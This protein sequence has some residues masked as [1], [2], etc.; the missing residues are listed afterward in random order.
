[1]ES[2]R[3]VGICGGIGAG[4]SVVSR[5]LRLRGYT[6]YDCDFEARR[7]MDTSALFKD[8]LEERFGAEILSDSPSRIIDRSRLAALV[9]S[10]DKALEWLNTRVHAMVRD[11][12]A[13]LIK[14]FG[15]DV[16]RSAEDQIPPQRQTLFIESAILASSGLLAC[17][18][19]VIWV[20]APVEIRVARA[21]SRSAMTRE[22]VEARMAAQ[23]IEFD[24]VSASGVGMTV[25]DNSGSLSVLSSL[26]F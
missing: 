18:D 3:V 21:M 12:V 16:C 9:F 22:Q 8:E 26:K 20:D 17:C 1:M 25:I 11:D 6:V 5:V 19:E 7:I 10:D 4:K 15:S 2:L 14:T 23:R 24:S 13:S